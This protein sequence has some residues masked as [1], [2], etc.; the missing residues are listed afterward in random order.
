MDYAIY[1]TFG[2]GQPQIILLFTQEDNNHRAK[3]AAR[4]KFKQLWRKA[5]QRQSSCLIKGLKGSQDEISYG[6][7]TSANTYVRV[8][9]YI[10]PL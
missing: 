5:L 3:A 4:E 10:A 1:M 2:D 9:L 8:R 6:Y 7:P